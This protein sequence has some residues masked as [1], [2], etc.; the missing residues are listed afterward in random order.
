MILKITA[1]GNKRMPFQRGPVKSVFESRAHHSI[2]INHI[3]FGFQQ[4]QDAV[5]S[6][7]TASN[8][9]IISIQNIGSNPY[10]AITFTFSDNP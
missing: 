1:A 3:F 9:C 6:S 4:F 10:E 7:G 2:K 8:V 5:Y